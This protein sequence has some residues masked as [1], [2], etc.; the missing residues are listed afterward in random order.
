MASKVAVVLLLVYLSG[1]TFG[2]KL[3]GNGYTD[4]LIAINPKVP[5]DP[6]LITQIQE[7][8]KEASRNLLDATKKHLYFKE[9]AILVPPNWN[10]GNYSRAK[11][12]VYDKANIIID[13]PNKLH[14]DQPYTLQYGECGSEGRYIHLTPDFMLKDDVSKYYGPRGKVFVHEW[15]HLRW[16]VFDEY[17]E[18]KPFY[19]SGSIIEATRCTINITGKYINKRDQKDCTTDPATGL[20]TED[21]VFYP[22]TQQKTSASIMY[23][24]GL[25]AVKEFCT[26][27][28]HNT[29]APNIQN[30]L[31]GNRGVEE[32][33]TSLSVDAGVAVVPT[34]PTILPTFTVVQRRQRVVC[35]V[36]DV[37]GSMS[38]GS[39]MLNLRQA[40]TLFI[41]KI[42]EDQAY[43]G[44]V[45]FTAMA[46][47]LEPLTLI[48]GNASRD[49]LVRSLPPSAGGGT[50]IC[51]G[52]EK[53]LEVLGGDGD[54]ARGDEIIL[55][56]DGESSINCQKRVKE[57]GATVH[58]ITLGPNANIGVKELSDISGGKYHNAADG[59]DSNDLVDIFASHTTSD[60]NLTKQTIQLESTGL[61]MIGW[62]NGSVSIDRTIGNKTS[63]LVIYER[64]SPD[65]LVLSPFTRT[66][67]TSHFQHDAPA[68]TLT[69]DIEGTAETGKWKYSLLNKE[70]TAQSMSMT[71]TSH[72][73][74]E[75]ISP[76]MVKTH[77]SQLSSNGSKPML[78]YAEV[79]QKGVPVVLADVMATLTS[80]KGDKHELKLQDNGAGADAFRNDGI[81]SSYFTK[82]TTGKYSLKVKVHNNDGMAR[83]SLRRHSGALYIPGYVVNGQ[84][85]MNPPKPPVSEDDLQADVG[86]F[87]RTAIGES[88]SVSLPPGVPPP[89]FPPN[90]ITDLN[91]EIEADKVLLTWTAPGED[92]DQGTATAYE[93][94]FS[95]DSDLLR[96]NFSTAHLVTYN[97]SPK[98]AG[99]PEKVSFTLFSVIKN[100]TTL[101]FAAKAEDK[102]FLK[103]ETSNIIQVT[104][105]VPKAPAPS[106]TDAPGG[107]DTSGSG[108]NITAIVISVTTV[109]MVACLIASVTM[110]SIKSRRVNQP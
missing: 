100:G 15:A 54:G 34:P 60:G 46:T 6:V 55:L 37:S 45:Q 3:T 107:P 104:K 66:Y 35:L 96:S 78:V 65:I 5:E 42:V 28:T 1:S 56:T 106:P 69:L 64:S 33:I 10:T 103:S 73:V 58:T 61:N 71:V 62:F 95:E 24:Q 59:V 67:D 8:F 87:S 90:K 27:E 68:K 110:C 22:D 82:L 18:E 92:M 57:S 30:R 31:C 16:G 89:N 84:V 86:S 94:R 72:A 98:K 39:R 80:D 38:A 20:Y 74:S 26:K 19:L 81:Y 63:F 4:I 75:A 41:Q 88:F 9:V 48:D 109:T 23:N 101:F 7:M 105:I 44:I 79:N 76:V 43:V 53:G 36:L 70:S 2:I 40:A 21:C 12:E 47:I 13:E 29:E 17:N 97:L 93:I 52:V 91:A 77:M 85:V 11:T 50:N 32:V 14:G 25:S 108:V 49:K 51:A 83:F 99:S 102:S